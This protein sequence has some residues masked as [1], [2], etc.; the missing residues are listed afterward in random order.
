MTKKQVVAAALY[1]LAG[2]LVTAYIAVATV[3]STLEERVVYLPGPASHILLAAAAIAA[4]AGLILNL[5]SVPPAPRRESAV[6]RTRSSAGISVPGLTR[7]GRL[8]ASLNIRNQSHRVT[9][10]SNGAFVGT[11]RPGARGGFDTYD[12][13]DDRVGWFPTVRDG[14]AHLERHAP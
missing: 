3:V 5:R 1:G 4:L 10:S 2:I 6:E 11:L 14:M 13:V 7:H 9:W 8:D 12:E